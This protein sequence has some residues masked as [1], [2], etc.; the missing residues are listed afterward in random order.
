VPSDSTSPL[1]RWRRAALAVVA[2]GGFLFSAA[3]AHATDPNVQ[4]AY[5]SNGACQSKSQADPPALG[6]PAGVNT[7]RKVH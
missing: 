7:G 4:G 3:P 5:S 6:R 1:A 2:T